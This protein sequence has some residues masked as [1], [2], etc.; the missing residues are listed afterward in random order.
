VKI[1]LTGFGPFK[2][3]RVNPSEQV[4]RRLAERQQR[5]AEIQLVT[6]VLPT[7]YVAA[8]RKLRRLIRRHRPDAV[9][10]LGVATRRDCISLE[11]VALNLDDEATP[12]N[13]GLV[14]R[15]SNI[16]R[17]GSDVYWSTLPLDKMKG[18]LRR[19]GIKASISNHAG[20]FLC[21]HA[22][23]VARQ[24]T[25]RMRRNVPCGF[26]HLPGRSRNSKQ[27]P[28]IS[29]MIRAIDC[30]INVLAMQRSRSVPAY[31]LP[32]KAKRTAAMRQPNAAA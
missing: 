25:A 30:C 4:V 19:R 14:R 32:Q 9:L 16:A 1:L 8:S 13:T 31:A 15:G 21:N 12:D 17:A 23:Y 20:A 5:K 6:E 7:E 18:A 22:F 26:I 11:R 24:E 3:V 27:L 2:G 29:R 28:S 10:C